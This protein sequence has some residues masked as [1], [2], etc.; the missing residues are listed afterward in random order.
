[1]HVTS[2]FSD[3][4]LLSFFQ[5][6]S[7]EATLRFVWQ[8]ATMMEWSHMVIQK[9]LSPKLFYLVWTFFISSPECSSTGKKLIQYL[10]LWVIL[11]GGP[12]EKLAV[13]VPYIVGVLDVV[14]GST[15]IS[16]WSTS[17]NNK[18][19]SW[20]VYINFCVYAEVSLQIYTLYSFS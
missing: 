13:E 10:S 18:S 4:L 11:K 3:G 1:M 12:C 6:M 7:N 20:M 17:L 19:W 2:N 14:L 15:T 9:I 16:C 5:L 8:E